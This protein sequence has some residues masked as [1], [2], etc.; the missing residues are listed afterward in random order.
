[1][2]FRSSDLGADKIADSASRLIVR[3][4]A[5]SV[6]VAAAQAISK[7]GPIKLIKLIFTAFR[8]NCI[9]DYVLKDCINTFIRR[10]GK[11]ALLHESEDIGETELKVLV[12][13]A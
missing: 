8:L 12:E 4:S 1:M 3:D 7:V 5:N 11:D 10:F 6:R 2:L 9:N 13:Q